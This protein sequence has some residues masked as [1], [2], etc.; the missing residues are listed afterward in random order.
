[1]NKER[2][3]YKDQA[4]S[5]LSR[6]KWKKALQS[7][8]KHI[9][10]KPE[11]LRSRLKKAEL[12]ERIGK[13]QEAI[14]EYRELA[15]AYAGEGFLLQAISVNKMIL[16]IDPSSK[17]INERLGQLYVEK[18]REVKSSRPLPYI[19]FL[20]DL[21]EEE[22]RS[23]L[24][25]VQF[26]TFHKDVFLCREGEPGDSLMVI[27]RGEAGIYKEHSEGKE[28][29]I[30][31]LKEGDCFGEFG[32]FSDRK[33]HAGV[34][35][36]IECEVLEIS[37][38]ELEEI[39]KT[40][41]RVKEVL[42]DLFQKR[43]LDLLFASSPLFSPLTVPER[44]EVLKRFRALNIPE[45]TFVFKGGDPPHC[46]YMIK[47]GEVEIFT[48]DRRGR[49]VTLGKLGSGH[50]FGEIGVFFNTPRMAF[51]RTTRPSEL[52]ELTKEDFDD[53]L[54]KFPQLQSVVE[55]FSSKRLVRMKEILSQEW[56][57]RAKESMV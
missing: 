8:Q 20:S 21:N 44:E 53:L 55:E 42:E 37:R 56:V 6:G 26:R 16:R 25:R 1:M 4:L 15:E 5:S 41:P 19:S 46:L 10:R 11:D 12:L 27:C 23:L 29:W 36:L 50:L 32:F 34:K 52:L 22:L 35:S 30:R 24:G 31:N 7:L 48:Q 2:V 18:N 38:K 47:N 43:V 51:A 40:H 45:E 57:E 14:I 17:D 28:V 54:R 49:Q 3:S 9:D 13:K 33:R 39:I